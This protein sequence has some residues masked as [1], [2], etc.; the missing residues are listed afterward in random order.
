[1]DTGNFYTDDKE[2]EEAL[3]KYISGLIY[4]GFM[5]DFYLPNPKAKY[6]IND[7]IQ[8]GKAKIEE[9]ENKRRWLLIDPN[10]A[11]DLKQMLREE[12]EAERRKKIEP[13]IK[14]CDVN[15][16]FEYNI[17]EIKALKQKKKGIDQKLDEIY[18]ELEELEAYALENKLKTNYKTYIKYKDYIKPYA[19]WDS[20]EEVWIFSDTNKLQEVVNMVNKEREEKIK[21]RDRLIHEQNQIDEQ[22]HQI[23]EKLLERA[24]YVERTGYIDLTIFGEDG[25]MYTY[26]DTY[27]FKFKEDLDL[28][29]MLED[30]ENPKIEQVDLDGFKL[31]KLTVESTFVDA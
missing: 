26:H 6:T 10:F 21:E 18:K 17:E 30:I 31:W 7:L 16:P 25:D 8:Q 24:Y 4:G 22:L 1:V 19:K 28:F 9:D 27:Y 13:I 12:K 23:I 3:N 14:K 20:N 15:K 2:L 5:P 11:E 29:I